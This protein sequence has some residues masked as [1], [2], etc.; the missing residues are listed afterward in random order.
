MSLSGIFAIDGSAILVALKIA[1]ASRCLS[2]DDGAVNWKTEYCECCYHH[3]NLYSPNWIIT[4]RP[5][6]RD[7]DAVRDDRVFNDIAW[8]FIPGPLLVQTRYLS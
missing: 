2:G 8:V 5:C 1:S 3:R 6:Q 7:A 4:S